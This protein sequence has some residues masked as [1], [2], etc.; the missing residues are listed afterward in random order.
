MASAV[1]QD[2]QYVLRETLFFALEKYGE[3]FLVKLLQTFSQ[4][5]SNYVVVYCAENIPTEKW[6]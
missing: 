6:G 5:I 1:R 4:S 3:T 2:M